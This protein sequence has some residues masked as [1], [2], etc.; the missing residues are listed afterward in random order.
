M[1]TKEFGR[2]DFLK[3]SGLAAGAMMLLAVQGKLDLE[4]QI[5]YLDALVRGTFDGR[6]LASLD[7]GQNWI[8]LIDFGEQLSVVHLAESRG[9]LMVV[10]DMGG[11]M[12][13]LHSVDG[14]KWHTA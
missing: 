4:P 11:R 9:R 7:D 2:R 13:N 6:I 12:F 10:L 5:R 8:K 14:R 1:S 3:L